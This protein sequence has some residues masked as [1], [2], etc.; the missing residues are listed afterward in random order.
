MLSGRRI[1]PIERL[2][3]RR[4]LVVAQLVLGED[5]LGRS[6]EVGEEIR[7]DHDATNELG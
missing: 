7:I 5:R 2:T 4:A 1:E 6:L 3:H